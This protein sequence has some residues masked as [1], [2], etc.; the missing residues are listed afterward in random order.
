MANGISTATIVGN[1]TRDPES[2]SERFLTFSV[3]VNRRGKD[4]DGEWGDEA[5][6]FDV[7]VLG[8]RAAP[9]SGILSK[10]QGV[11]VFGDLVQERWESQDGSKR[12]AVRVI[13]REVVLHGSKSER[14]SERPDTGDEGDGDASET[15]LPF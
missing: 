4:A 3:A 7:K 14:E 12:S 9:L 5:H 2:K 6:F 10:G 1:L 13:A 15:G 8:N 11:T